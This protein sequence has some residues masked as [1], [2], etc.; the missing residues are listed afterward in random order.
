MT[1]SESATSDNEFERYEHARNGSFKSPARDSEWRPQAD[2]RSLMKATS[3]GDLL[4]RATSAAH[5]SPRASRPVPARGSPTGG[6]LQRLAY[7]KPDSEQSSNWE[8]R[9]ESLT[10]SPPTAFARLSDGGNSAA[11][12]LQRSPNSVSA[13]WQNR[14]LSSKSSEPVLSQESRSQRDR[15]SSSTQGGQGG[16]DSAY[17]D[18]TW[19]G[20]SQYTPPRGVEPHLHSRAQEEY[21]LSYGS[22]H[23][24]SSS[25]YHPFSDRSARVDQSPDLGH[26][27]APTGE[28][29]RQPPVEQ[30]QH[31]RAEPLSDAQIAE[32][33]AIPGRPAESLLN[34]DGTAL[35]SKNILTI[36]LQKAQNAVSL[37]GANN[38][39]EAIAAYKQAVRLLQEVMERIAPKPGRKAKSNREE[40]RRRLKVIVS[41]LMVMRRRTW[42]TR[43]RRTARHVCR[44]NSASVLHLLSGSERRSGRQHTRLYAW[45]RMAGEPERYQ[46][47]ADDTPEQGPMPA[48]RDRTSG[49]SEREIAAQLRTDSE[50]RPAERSTPAIAVLS[51]TPTTSSYPE[52]NR[53]AQ[54]SR[55]ERASQSSLDDK[56]SKGANL[57]AAD[58][59]SSGPLLTARSHVFGIDDE[60]RTP[61]TPYFDVM[62]EA[63]NSPTGIPEEIPG[64]EAP[65]TPTAE[66]TEKEKLIRRSRSSPTLNNEVTKPLPI[67]T[68]LDELSPQH[69]SGSSLKASPDRSSPLVSPSTLGGTISQRRRGHSMSRGGDSSSRGSGLSPT[70]ESPN[71]HSQT[72][73]MARFES[74]QSNASS[75]ADSDRSVSSSI[76]GRQRALSQPA[77]RP[78]LPAAFMAQNGS[79]VPPVPA[80]PRQSRPSNISVPSYRLAPGDAPNS[81]ISVGPDPAL[82]ARN[83]SAARDNLFAIPLPSA[84]IAPQASFA[85]DGITANPKWMI[86]PGQSPQSSPNLAASLP[87]SVALRPLVL[88]RMLHLSISNNGFVS[89]RIHVSKMV[90]MQS[91]SKLQ[92]VEAKL[93]AVE[94]LEAAIESIAKAGDG[95]LRNPYQGQISPNQAATRLSTTLDE[96]DGLMDEVQSTLSK[97]VASV[98][99]ISGRKGGVSFDLLQCSIEAC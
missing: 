27:Y 79:I 41:T 35:N 45:S 9:R 49:A 59:H 57:V 90:W 50:Q 55:E 20:S 88:M 11:G 63:V 89:R 95:L 75:T 21:H 98:P 54:I 67:G 28:A 62:E 73:E 52:A 38:V 83:A 12:G 36:A 92:A 30:Q 93:R 24:A 10:T 74:R 31:E 37:D 42:L 87:S 43:A 86:L 17:A 5:T 44:S 96:L 6:R 26:P 14:R 33:G 85:A 53:Q 46:P 64:T 69:L 91:T 51:N 3:H 48:S 58:P 68:R 19:A 18:G 71:L 84:G 81:A 82:T 13:P 1:G 61:A 97:K 77:R 22:P 60:L 2:G 29:E 70:D 7:N 32:L 78:S 56:P 66:P 40:E 8:T 99:S 15:Y 34:P 39:P 94:L 4:G 25:T 23:L 47:K 16:R 76:S 80:L 65:A 72:A